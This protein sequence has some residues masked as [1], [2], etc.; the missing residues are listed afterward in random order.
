M[1]WPNHVVKISH[2]D[3]ERQ[4]DVRPLRFREEANGRFCKRVV[5]ANVPLFRFCC[6]VAPFCVPLFQFWGSN[7]RQN[8][9]L[10]TT[11]LRTPERFVPSSGLQSLKPVS[12][13]LRLKMQSYLYTR[14]TVVAR[15]S[16]YIPSPECKK[17]SLPLTFRGYGSTG[18]KQV[19][20]EVTIRNMS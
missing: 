3:R 20:G 8:H 18:L 9:P 4:T 11:L 15:T 6:A 2:C 10:E 19:S 16:F 17:S 7:I 5:L 14:G 12:S 1:E 13:T